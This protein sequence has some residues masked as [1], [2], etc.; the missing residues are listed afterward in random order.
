MPTACDHHHSAV[1]GGCAKLDHVYGPLRHHQQPQ[2]RH[3]RADSLR[4]F[5]GSSGCPT[6]DFARSAP[7]PARRKG[8]RGN[9]SARHLPDCDHGVSSTPVLLGMHPRKALLRIVCGKRGFR[10]G[11]DCVGRSR[12]ARQRVARAAAVLCRHRGQRNFA[13]PFACCDQSANSKPVKRKAHP[14]VRLYAAF[15]VRGLSLNAPGHSLPGGSYA[16]QR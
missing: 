8:D 12:T 4:V 15:Q 11:E 14:G 6:G 9:D 3:H 2:A 1:C 13:E 10:A 7:E 16:G 5:P